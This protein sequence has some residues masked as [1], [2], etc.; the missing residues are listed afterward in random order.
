MNGKKL[1]AIGFE[2]QSGGWE[3]R[4]S[5][6]KGSLGKK[7][8]SLI[9]KDSKNIY[10]FEGFFFVEINENFNGDL[11]VLNSISMYKKSKEILKNYEEIFLFLDNDSAG[12]KMKN[13][14]LL[15][16]SNAVDSS[17]MY[18]NFK[19]LN[20]KKKKKKL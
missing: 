7:D 16:F 2:N 6:Y 4:N 10:V 15:D 11:L 8:I 14:M 9:T 1:Y 5:F 12:E 17:L 18:K 20:E 3:L 13:E 19:D